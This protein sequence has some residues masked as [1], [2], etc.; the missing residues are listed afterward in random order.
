MV[1]TSLVFEG[2]AI[3]L[4][5]HASASGTVELALFESWVL[6]PSVV[7]R[8]RPTH[9]LDA[10]WRSC[11]VLAIPVPAVHNYDSRLAHRSHRLATYIVQA[12]G[13]ADL[14]SM[15]TVSDRPDIPNLLSDGANP[16]VR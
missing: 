12:T 4:V 15:Y 8:A 13:L 11:R 2:Y 9:T 1:G 10:C 3:T 14:S 5:S 16:C 6:I 7:A